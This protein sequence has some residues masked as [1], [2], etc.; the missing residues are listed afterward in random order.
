MQLKMVG[1]DHSKASISLREQ[2]SFTKNEAKETMRSLVACEDIYGC[3]IL[4][5]CNRTELWVAG[6]RGSTPEPDHILCKIKGIEKERCENY[7]VSREDSEAISHLLATTCGMNSKIFGEDQIITQIKAALELSRECNATDRVIE[8]VFQHSICAGKKVKSSV[9]LTNFS[10]SVANKGIEHI[11]KHFGEFKGLNCLIIGNGQMGAHIAKELIVRG[12]N[13]KMTLRKKY[14]IKEPTES[15]IPAG[16]QMVEYQDRY[17]EMKD[18]DVVIS[19]TLSPHFTLELDEIKREYVKE[20]GLW[21]DLAVPRDIDPLISKAYAVNIL[22]I[23]TIGMTAMNKDNA[24]NIRKAQKILDHYEDTINQWLAFRKQI[25]EIRQVT[26]LTKVD[27]EKRLS[28]DI[29]QLPLDNMQKHELSKS[30]EAAAGRS[31]NKLLCGL[32]ETLPEE[33]WQLCFNSLKES[34]KKETLKN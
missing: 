21:L 33:Y 12:A 6:S 32:K 15:L 9:R 31:V 18:A 16:C 3:L 20:P 24:E 27:V 34:A 30:I 11:A 28:K 2:F 17:K 4:S 1:I 5:T 7:L 23:D 8:K 14:H 25:P 10:P 26:A 29:K 13:V 22:D 19:A